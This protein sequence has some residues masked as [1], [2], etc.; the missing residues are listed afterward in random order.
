M[1]ESHSFVEPKDPLDF[2]YDIVEPGDELAA[3]VSVE[4]NVPVSNEVDRTLKK[5]ARE[6]EQLLENKDKRIARHGFAVKQGGRPKT[7]HILREFTREEGVPHPDA[8]TS[9]G[10]TPEPKPFEDPE[11]ILARPNCGVKR[12]RPSCAQ[13]EEI[14][15]PAPEKQR[16][17]RYHQS[18][19]VASI[20][21]QAFRT[22]DPDALLSRVS[23][24]QREGMRRDD[25]Q[26]KRGRERVLTRIA[27]D[28]TWETDPR[29]NDHSI[30]DELAQKR[31]EA[32]D[33]F[34][35]NR[36][37]ERVETHVRVRGAKRRKLLSRAEEVLIGRIMK[38]EEGQER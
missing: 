3:A 33:R 36:R 4:V 12:E 6:R 21:R 14:P 18:G 32:I 25:Q 37:L 20:L 8:P 15:T 28:N 7:H 35:T 29:V 13:T 31:G 38:D 27:P 23:D 17:P 11:G 34:V 2:D 1:S 9:M 24:M 10:G 16:K 22:T 26:L 5:Q 19:Q 30:T